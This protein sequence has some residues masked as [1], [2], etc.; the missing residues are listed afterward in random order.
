MSAAATR[1]VTLAAVLLLLANGCSTPDRGSSESTSIPILQGTPTQVSSAQPNSTG[2]MVRANVHST[3]VYVADGVRQPPSPQWI[4]RAESKGSITTPAISGDL[5]FFGRNGRL[6]ALDRATGTDRWTLRLDN[7]SISAPA[8]AGD[9]VYVGA[10]EELHAYG[11]AKGEQKWIFRPRG[12]TDD[13]YFSD[14]IIVDGTVY[15]G[16]WHY[17]YAIDSVTGQE[18]WR[19]KLAG[20]PRS[21]ATV[22]RDT[23]YIGTFNPDFEGS[24]FLYAFDSKTGQER[25]KLEA[26]QGGISA[27]VAVT[28]DVV[29]VSSNEEMLLALD[30]S[31][32]REKWRYETEPGIM[33]APAVAY[34]RVYFADSGVLYALDVRT[35]QRVWRQNVGG[36]FDRDPIIADGILYVGNT[37]TGLGTLLSGKLTAVLHALDAHSGEEMWKHR[38]EG[39][40]SGEPV[41]AEGT[42]YFGTSEGTLFALK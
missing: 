25:W 34:G 3:G 37:E 10:W 7:V 13:R 24:A 40:F 26:S 22:Y 5:V 12:E 23:I 11:V 30:A 31:S 19:V 14:P 15:S 18:K 29:Y 21:I 20:V 42:I 38:V 17:F 9:T 2:A 4:Y 16:G 33:G 41:V 35:G 36:G 39:S 27:A 6:H 8:V 28:N 32:G 1:V